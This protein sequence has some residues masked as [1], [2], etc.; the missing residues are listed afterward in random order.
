MTSQRAAVQPQPDG[1]RQNDDVG[2]NDFGIEG[3]IHG[4]DT[5]KADWMVSG[6]VR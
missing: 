1:P 6:D 4:M 3:R 2:P 5:D